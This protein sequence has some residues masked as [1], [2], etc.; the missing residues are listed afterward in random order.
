MW[1]KRDGMTM[2]LPR[3]WR[4]ALQLQTTFFNCPIFPPSSTP[5]VNATCW[6]KGMG[7]CIWSVHVTVSLVSESFVLYPAANLL[8]SMWCSKHRDF[9]LLFLLFT[10]CG[11]KIKGKMLRNGN[12]IKLEQSCL[13]KWT[14]N[15]QQ[16]SNLVICLNR[17]FTHIAQYGY[18][19]VHVS[20]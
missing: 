17:M 16:R 5:P 15:L 1:S 12:L 6:L 3:E 11:K 9:R 13:H 4:Y 7:L 14:E 19:A 8:S 20:I 2:S 10:K 18:C